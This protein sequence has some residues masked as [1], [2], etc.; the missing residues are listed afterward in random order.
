MET[1][2]IREL[3]SAFVPEEILRD[4]E[5]REVKKECGVYRLYMDEKDD[6]WCLPHDHQQPGDEQDRTDSRHAQDL[7]ASAAPIKVCGQD[8]DE[9]QERDSG[10]G[11]ELRPVG[12]D[13]LSQ[14][15]SGG[16]QVS[17]PPRNP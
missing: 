14:R 8:Q 4:F 3:I 17:R 15:I 10:H 16:G 2:E 9:G 7:R 11:S 5:Q 6:R 12:E 13:D 1:A